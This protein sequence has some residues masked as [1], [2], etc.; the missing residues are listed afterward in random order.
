MN[1]FGKRLSFPASFISCGSSGEHSW[2]V[3]P[4]LFLFTLRA[5]TAFFLALINCSISITMR[6]TKKTD[7]TR[8]SRL[9]ETVEG[10]RQRAK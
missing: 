4:T 10:E 9:K 7:I 1:V 3:H 6:P 5:F 8:S 2:G